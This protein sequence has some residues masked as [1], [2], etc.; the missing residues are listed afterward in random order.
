MFLK[1]NWTSHQHEKSRVRMVN[2][3]E[4]AATTITTPNQNT[5]SRKSFCFTHI[6]IFKQSNNQKNTQ[7]ISKK[8]R[9]AMVNY[10]GCKVQQRS[11]EW[12]STCHRLPW[13]NLGPGHFSELLG[14]KP[15]MTQVLLRSSWSISVVPV[16]VSR[17]ARRIYIY[18]YT[19][20]ILELMHVCFHLCMHFYDDTLK[21]WE[22]PWWEQWL[23][24]P[25]F[26][27]EGHIKQWWRV[28]KNC[29]FRDAFLVIR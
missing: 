14:R 26:W 8:L 17:M 28:T 11:S 10:R 25:S 24:Q 2:K 19:L 16:R 5:S 29:S 22:E 18:I 13:Q 23:W 15:R 6:L 27:T 21:F 20:K 7:Q 12:I 9:T 1:Y 4:K 3:H